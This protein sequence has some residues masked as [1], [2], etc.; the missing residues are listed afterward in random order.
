MEQYTSF[1]QIQAFLAAAECGSFR[2]AAEVLS[3]TQ[4]SVSAR[5]KALESE[6]GVPLFHRLPR[7]VR[8]T[9]MGQVFLPYAQRSMET[10]REGRDMLDGARHA[11]AGVLSMAVAR[12]IGTYVL[13]GI[14]RQF[15]ERHPGIN[16]RIKVGR[17]SEI[18]QMVVSEEVQLGMTR[19]L[20]HPD[21]DETHLYDE[22]IVLVTD[23]S[24]PFARR[25]EASIQ[26]VAQE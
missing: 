6:L 20:Q 14:L 7:G 16:V 23:G 1:E 18:L 8:L 17:S 13:P 19:F 21:V 4:P 15:R 12:T 24:H 2:R 9:Q 26:E 3:G 10:L 5:I 11:Y 25:G 22:E